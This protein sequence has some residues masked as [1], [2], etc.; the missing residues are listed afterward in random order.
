MLLPHHETGACI[1]ICAMIAVRPV[2]FVVF[3]MYT[4]ILFTARLSAIGKV[5]FDHLPF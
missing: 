4:I 3:E 2:Q 5:D 1:T